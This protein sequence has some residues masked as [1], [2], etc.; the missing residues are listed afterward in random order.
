MT[1]K[2]WQSA[3]DERQKKEVK[4]ATMY[5]TDYVHG[6]DGHTR[7]LL[8]AKLAKLLDEAETAKTRL[9]ELML[10]AVENKRSE[11]LSNSNDPSWAEHFAELKNKLLQLLEE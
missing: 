10:Q 7:L 6:T 3:L 11:V 2:G 8:V 1:H 4:F 9:A 5:A